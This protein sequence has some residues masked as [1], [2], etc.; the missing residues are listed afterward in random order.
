MKL[1]NKLFVVDLYLGAFSALL[2]L[3]SV[4]IVKIEYFHKKGLVFDKII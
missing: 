2:A 4:K 3:E 1:Q